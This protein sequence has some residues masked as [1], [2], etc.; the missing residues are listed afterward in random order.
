MKMAPPPPK[1]ARD[2][3]TSPP[4]TVP[5]TATVEEAA[6]VMLERGI[7]SV[8]IVDASS[9]LAGIVTQSDFSSKERCVPFSTFRAPQLFRTWVGPEGVDKIFA[10]A[11]TLPVTEIMTRNVVTGKEDDPVAEIMEKMLRAD[12]NRIPIVRDEVPV[13]IVARHDLLKMMVGR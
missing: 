12:V 8:L 10:D 1:R 11:R 7:G 3:M 6:R 2:I 9:R 5:A 4:V 13:G